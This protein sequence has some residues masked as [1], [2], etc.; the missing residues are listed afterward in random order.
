MGGKIE[1]FPEDVYGF[2]GHEIG[3]RSNSY[4]VLEHLR[5]MYSRFYL[6]SDDAPSSQQKKW[7]GTSRL[8]IQVIDN[9]ASSN[10]LLLN[11]N[12]YL[13]RLSKTDDHCNVT[14]EDL[15][16][17]TCDSIKICDPLNFIQGAILRTVCLLAKDYHLIHAGAVSWENE[18][19]IFPASTSM[20]KTTLVAKLVSHGL[21]FLSDEVACLNLDRGIVE[22]FPR[23]L[24]I[25]HGSRGLLGLPLEPNTTALDIEDIAPGSLSNPCAPRYILFLRG[26]GDKPRLECISN[27]NALFELFKF[28]ISPIDDP[29]FLLFKFAPLLDKI[30]CFNLVMGDLD[31][32]ANLVMGLV[33]SGKNH[34][35]GLKK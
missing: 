4:E 16:T 14:Y 9:L 11:D 21:R 6:G 30:Q 32:T 19:V 2:L 34:R 25:R 8:E 35:N 17:L 1:F 10:E 12:F 26:F 3:I 23:K 5:S 22:P 13:Y 28:S 18:G 29:A 33:N 31:E 27:S 7:G 24:N 15:H 20:G